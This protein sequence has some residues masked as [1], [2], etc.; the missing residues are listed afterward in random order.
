METILHKTQR[1]ISYISAY[2]LT[3]YETEQYNQYTNDWY[4]VGDSSTSL[5]YIT[6]QM[7]HHN[8]LLINAA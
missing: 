4:I 5:E 1:I 3:V 6:S 8:L 7:N 2:G